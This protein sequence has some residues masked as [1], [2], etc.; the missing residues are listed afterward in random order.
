ME[1]E[2]TAGIG[3]TPWWAAERPR[4][5][6]MRPDESETVVETLALAF[7]HDPV[8]GWMLPGQHTR[9]ARSRRAFAIFGRRY[10]WRRNDATYVTDN[11]EGVACWIPPDAV[12]LGALAE[13]RLTLALAPATRGELP[14]VLRALK[15]M[16][17]N[18]PHEPHWYL[19]A[20]GVRPEAQGRGLGDALLQPVLERADADGVPAYL[21]ATTPRNRA[22][23]ERNGFVVTAEPRLPDDG[24]PFWPMWREPGGGR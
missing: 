15:A 14:R 2:A 7:A 9:A 12:E 23:Y 4:I 19:P 8:L 20:V 10:Y 22:L 21:E 24:P 6:T 18:H 5:R 11:A 1:T 3:G 17:E 13:L 16:E